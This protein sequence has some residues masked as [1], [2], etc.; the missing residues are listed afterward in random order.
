MNKIN[1]L[2][3]EKK[4]RCRALETDE[5]GLEKQ[6]YFLALDNIMTSFE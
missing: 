3:S 4:D 5:G 1:V 6:F 2:K